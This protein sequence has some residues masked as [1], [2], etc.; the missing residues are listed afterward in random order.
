MLTVEQAIEKAYEKVPF[1][2]ARGIK[3]RVLLRYPDGRRVLRIEFKTNGS[4]KWVD[5]NMLEDSDA[6]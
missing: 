2:R 3:N 4:P 6:K 5:I 1:S